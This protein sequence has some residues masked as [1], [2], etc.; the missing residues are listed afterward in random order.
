MFENTTTPSPSGVGIG[1]DT[2]TLPIADTT[3]NNGIVEPNVP[4]SPQVAPEVI[5]EIFKDITAH[6]KGRALQSAFDKRVAELEQQNKA[7]EA[8]LLARQAPAVD[9]PL[10]EALQAFEGD[11]EAALEFLK[12]KVRMNEERTR[13]Q[14]L[15]AEQR[16][17]ERESAQ[18]VVTQATE[19][20]SEAGLDWSSE[21]AQAFRKAYPDPK[22]EA[23]NALS[24]G[25][26]RYQQKIVSEA[27]KLA[28]VVA[29]DATISALK[30]SGAST[31]GGGKSAI[32]TREQAM[33]A[34][35]ERGDLAAYIAAK[36]NK[37]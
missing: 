14:Q 5:E 37:E 11:Q 34:A 28:P 2:V 27:K 26:I 32:P 36:N 22:P 23:L 12:A 17:I 33:K 19:M 4:S 29:R 20:L 24:R 7:L 30:S 3:G 13:E 8:K 25:L 9:V 21:F 1:S 6:P 31:I 10:D 35:F 18:M 15:Q 16:R